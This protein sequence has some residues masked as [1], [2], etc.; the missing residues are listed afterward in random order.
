MIDDILKELKKEIVTKTILGGI[1]ELDDIISHPGE[2]KEERENRR[3]LE[4]RKKKELERKNKESQ[5]EFEREQR[6]I[7]SQQK[8]EE[9]KDKKYW[10][11]NISKL[12]L[13]ILAIAIGILFTM[14]GN[15]FIAIVGYILA[16]I[17]IGY[18]FTIEF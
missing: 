9:M 12:F 2:T 15:D 1:N 10:Y 8:L 6:R 11:E 3:K 18:S 16:C 17:I 5:L 13:R 7:K 14:P 4:K